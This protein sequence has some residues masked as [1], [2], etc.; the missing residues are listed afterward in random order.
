M[1]SERCRISSRPLFISANTTFSSY[2][3]RGTLVEHGI[4]VD[5]TAAKEAAALPFQLATVYL[6]MLFA[7]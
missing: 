2:I 4:A 1:Q 3:L 6:D 7:L 5:E